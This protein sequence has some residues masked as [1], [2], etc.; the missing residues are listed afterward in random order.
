MANGIQVEMMELKPVVVKKATE[1]RAGGDGQTPFSKM[2]KCDDFIYIFHGERFSKGGALV[3][4]ILVLE[5]SLGNKFIEVIKG[6][7][8]VCPLSRRRLRLFLVPILLRFLRCHFQIHSPRV[9]R[10]LWGKG[11]GDLGGLAFFKR[12]KVGC[13]SIWGILEILGG[14]QIESTVFTRCYRGVK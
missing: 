5:K 9:A 1:K 3:D 14:L 12:E 6:A 8:T 4:K 2:V 7:L 11:R 13:G 10:R